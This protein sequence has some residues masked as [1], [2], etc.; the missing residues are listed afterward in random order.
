MPVVIACCKDLSIY[1][2]FVVLSSY[3][4]LFGKITFVLLVKVPLGYE[5]AL[6][7]IIYKDYQGFLFLLRQLKSMSFYSF[8]IGIDCVL[9]AD[10][11]CKMYIPFLSVER[12][13]TRSFPEIA[14]IG[15]P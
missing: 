9:L 3:Y 5:K 14:R 11:I 12:L 2:S 8:K 15:A 1:I 7:I 6:I 13:T 10:V 4:F